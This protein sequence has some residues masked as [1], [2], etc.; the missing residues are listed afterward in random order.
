MRNFIALIPIL[1]FVNI[2]HST[3]WTPAFVYLQNQNA[4]HDNRTLETI[5]KNT[6]VS[7][8]HEGNYKKIKPLTKYAQTGNYPKI[9]SYYR[10]DILPAKVY[11]TPDSDAV[12]RAVIP[13]KNATL[14]G[15]PLKSFTY[16]YYCFECGGVG[17]YATFAPMT[18][19]QYHSL[20]QK[21]QFE[22]YNEEEDEC[23]NETSAS[24]SGNNKALH[25][26]L[27]ISC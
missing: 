7:N 27:H 8:I 17:F 16:E 26:N 25:L 13:L 11:K 15:F 23:G 19:T 18:I 12:L 3:D 4:N 2:A 9:A 14:Y 21:I 1:T 10:A 6:F 5:M 24:F 20:T 22:Q